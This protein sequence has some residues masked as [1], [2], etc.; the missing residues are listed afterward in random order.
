[1]AQGARC[2]ACVRLGVRWIPIF[3]STFFPAF[4]DYYRLSLFAKQ[5]KTGPTQEAETWILS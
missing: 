1:M 2:F 4:F 5:G 3:P